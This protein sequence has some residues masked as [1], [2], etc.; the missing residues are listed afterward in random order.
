MLTF[1]DNKITFSEKAESVKT[2]LPEVIN[3]FSFLKIQQQG[4]PFYREFRKEQ[5]VS[6]WENV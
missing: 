6:G 4:Y 1:S 3:T 2:T 5:C